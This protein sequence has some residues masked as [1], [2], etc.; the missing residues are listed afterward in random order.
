MKKYSIELKWALIFAAMSLVWMLLE[1]LVGLHGTHIDKH[2]T[3]TNLIA[4]PAIA[5]YVFALL[6]KR[7]KDYGGV[8]TWKQGFISGLIITLIVTVLSPLTQVITS[9]II[10][11]DYFSNVIEYAVSTGKMDRAAAEQYFNL[12]SYIV[13]GLIGAPVMGVLTSA[14]VALFTRRKDLD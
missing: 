2:A 6:E 11:P 1:K 7:R 3:Y 12:G 9:K 5:V 4:I 13:L 8:M 14:V 10:T